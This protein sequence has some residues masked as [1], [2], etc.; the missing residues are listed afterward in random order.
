V[1]LIRPRRGMVS[2]DLA[3]LWRY[4]ELFGF[5]VWRDVL[6]RY[7]QTY[8]GIAWAVLQP[9]MFMFVFTFVGKVAKFPTH[10]APYAII[11]LAALLPWQFFST[12]LADSSTSLLTSSNLISKVYFPRLIV[13]AAA[14]LGGFVDF[15][16]NALLFVVME[17]I[18]RVPLRPELIFFPFFF[19]YAVLAAFGAGVWFSALSVKYR[20]VKYV[21]PFLTRIGLYACPVAYVSTVVPGHWQFLYNLNPLVGII[22]GFRWCALG[23]DFAPDFTGLVLSFAL[24]VIVTLTGVAFFRNTERLFADL[25]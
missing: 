18:F 21:V 14:V 9:L 17:L 11:T 10:G 6:I 16:V 4:R 23:P 8:L 15:C 25:I 2:L 1:R 12:A 24:T 19:L 7:K 5:L 20:D 22:D 13:P 3:E